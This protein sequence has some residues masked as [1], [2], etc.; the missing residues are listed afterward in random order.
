[1]WKDLGNTLQLARECEVAMPAAAAALQMYVSVQ[2]THTDEDYSVVL[3][4]MQDLARGVG[5]R[6]RASG[7]MRRTA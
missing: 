7:A 3:R 4:L 6:P 5:E 2:A 1:M